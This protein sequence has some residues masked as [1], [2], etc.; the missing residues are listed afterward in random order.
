[1]RGVEGL[2]GVNERESIKREV[3]RVFVLG[4]DM[5]GWCCVWICNK[6]GPDWFL[7]QKSPRTID[8]NS[9][10]LRGLLCHLSKL[11]LRDQTCH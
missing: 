6:K 3:G 11:S 4:Q 5:V 9:E 2:T 10:T 7:V 8:V 1:M